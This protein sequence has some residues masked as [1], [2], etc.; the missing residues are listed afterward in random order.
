[1][2][3]LEKCKSYR[4][5]AKSKHL[6][7]QITEPRQT[8]SASSILNRYPFHIGNLPV[9]YDL[10]P[11]LSMAPNVW[12]QAPA[13]MMDVSGNLGQ[14]DQKPK[15]KQII[16]AFPLQWTFSSSILPSLAKKRHCAWSLIGK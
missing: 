1:M 13:N 12:P 4:N 16:L 2:K 7:I 11:Q 3:F 5:Y 15:Q 8:H 9:V 10:P 14:N 6:S